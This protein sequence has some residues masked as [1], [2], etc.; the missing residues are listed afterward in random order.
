MTVYHYGL[1]TDPHEL[2]YTMLHSTRTHIGVDT[3][4]HSVADITMLGLGISDDP[5][6]A[7][8]ITTDD[9]DFP[10]VMPSFGQFNDDDLDDLVAYLKTLE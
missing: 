1:N 4:T 2:W 6:D 3:E 8:Y 10:A 9:D 7:F 5:D